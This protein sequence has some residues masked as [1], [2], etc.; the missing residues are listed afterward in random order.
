MFFSAWEFWIRAAAVLIFF[1]LIIFLWLKKQKQLFFWLL[2]F[3]ISILPTMLAFSL[4]W[5]V[6]ER[7]IYLGSLGIIAMFAILWHKLNTRV[8]D[9]K[10]LF[11]LVGILIVLGLGTRTVIRNQDWRNQDTLW[12]ATVKVAPSGQVIHNNLGDMY[13]RHKQYDKSIKEY[14]TAIGINPKYADAM[15]NLANTYLEINNVEQAIYWYEQA[16]KF[17]PHLWQSYQNLGAI[18]FQLNDL[19]KAEELFGQAVKINPENENLKE[20]LEIIRAKIQ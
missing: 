3:L 19:Q 14:L 12:L 17:G 1:A 2:F 8:F 18:Y 16:I 15:H 6:A 20:N 4:A 7:Y 13:G 11:W 10:K 9:S 5:I